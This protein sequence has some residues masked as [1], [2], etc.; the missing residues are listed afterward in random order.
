MKSEF[1]MTNVRKRW[2]SKMMAQ[3]LSLV[4]FYTHLGISHWSFIRH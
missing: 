3:I 2:D 1:L 4:C